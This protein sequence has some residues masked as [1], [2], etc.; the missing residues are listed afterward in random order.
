MTEVRLCTKIDIIDVHR[1]LFSHNR[2]GGIPVDQPTI[3]EFEKRFTDNV[4]TFGYFVNGILISFLITK[5]LIEIPSWYVLMMSSKNSKIFN[6]KESGFA[7]LFDSAVEYWEKQYVFSFIFIQP[8]NHRN[9]LN[10]K[11]TNASKNLKKYQ[12]PGATLE[13]IKK[14]TISSSMLISKLCKNNT[15]TRDMIVK[16]VFRQDYLQEDFK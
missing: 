9:F 12:I 3:E 16:W 15:F 2:I 5:K 10:G 8:V 1:I 7:N 11:I 4:I 6:F 14:G 13:V